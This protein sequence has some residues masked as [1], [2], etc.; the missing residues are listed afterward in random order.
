M[1]DESDIFSPDMSDRDLAARLIRMGVIPP[2]NLDLVDS[3]KIEEITSD[4]PTV[5]ACRYVVTDTQGQELKLDCYD[6]EPE[7]LNRQFLQEL[8]GHKFKSFPKR[9]ILPEYSPDAWKGF[10]LRDFAGIDR[11]AVLARFRHWGIPLESS[12]LKS[13]FGAISPELN[14][15]RAEEML[16]KNQTD[17]LSRLVRMGVIEPL[18]LDRVSI[19]QAD[20]IIKSLPALTESEIIWKGDHDYERKRFVN[21]AEF[22]ISRSAGFTPQSPG[23]MDEGVTDDELHPSRYGGYRHFDDPAYD[24]E[25]RGPNVRAGAHTLHMQERMFLD[26]HEGVEDKLIHRRENITGGYAWLDYFRQGRNEALPV[27]HADA[28]RNAFRNWGIPVKRGHWELGFAKDVKTNIKEAK[29]IFYKALFSKLANAGI[30]PM[31]PKKE[32]HSLDLPKAEAAAAKIPLLPEQE[33]PGEW[34]EFFK[35]KAP[36]SSMEIV[37][38]E[39]RFTEAGV[40]FDEKLILAAFPNRNSGQQTKG[41]RSMKD[42]TVDDYKKMIGRLTAS[43]RMDRI[44]TDEFRNLSLEDARDYVRGYDEPATDK[45]KN[46][47]SFM[48]SE[49]RLTI[50]DQEISQ[51]SRQEASLIIDR[52]PRMDFPANEPENPMSESTRKELKRMIDNEEIPQMPYAR[53][54]RLSEEEAR[55]KIDLVYARRPISEKQANFIS[56]TLKAGSFPAKTIKELFGRSTITQADVAK[57]N[58]LQ[59]SRLIGSLPAT[60]KQIEAVKQLVEDQRIPAPDHYDLT[61]AEAREILDKAYGQRNPLKPD[62]PATKRQKETLMELYNN[63]QLPESITPNK[64][65]S[66]TVEDASELIDESPAS[67]SQKDLIGRFVHEG[68]LEPIPR[69]E[70]ANM[71]RGS[72]SLLIDVATGKRPKADLADFYGADHPATERQIKVLKELQEKGKIPEI[73]ANITREAA[74]QLITDVSNGEPISPQQLA[75]LDRKIAENKIPVLSDADKAK[76]T[77]GD[78]TRLLK[79]SKKQEAAAKEA[80]S[81]GT[82]EHG[83]SKSREKE[84]AGMRR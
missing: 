75:I 84:P 46:V 32:W 70:F 21:L 68:T 56:E 69:E 81:A 59:A 4:L 62:G 8:S 9:Q 45:Q 26:R 42:I 5:Y 28:L 76:L 29:L 63:H 47:L 40:W 57:M 77:Q 36:E 41:F 78:F 1:P 83:K 13:G 18:D 53:L 55:A 67:S 50:S 17:L 7:G 54:S 72:A 60:E 38:M 71:T 43:G 15:R 35:Q 16:R 61:S 22:R 12:R 30:I 44:S 24:S 6:L 82:R 27:G 74:S 73:P 66:M 79:E 64:I 2:M 48:A 80:P 52:A 34:L 33:T 25:L 31:M 58:Q 10:L 51:L 3:E 23:E 65:N 39:A 20:D 37:Q 14:E 11:K 49:D 19:G